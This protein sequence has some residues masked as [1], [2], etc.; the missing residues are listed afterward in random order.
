MPDKLHPVGT[1]DVCGEPIP[2]NMWYTS[3]G[4]PRLHCSIDCRNAANSRRGAAVRSRQAKARVRRGIWKNPLW[5]ESPESRRVHASIAG[6]KGRLQ[7]VAAGTW[8]N[9][10]LSEAA[11]T[12]LSRPRVHAEQPLVHRAMEL[13]RRGM[14]LRELPG[15]VH[16][17]Y[18]AYRRDLAAQNRE[19]HRV[20]ARASY[21]HRQ[22]KMTEEERAAQRAKWRAANHRRQARG[23]KRAQPVRRVSTT[24]STVQQSR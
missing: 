23:Y 12:K 14:K 11:R 10:A 22:A 6:R 18:N 3:K 20:R 24:A 7:D 13:M 21:R 1:C 17:A 16:L 19:H 5:L 2:P 9:P 4:K 8:R 15:E